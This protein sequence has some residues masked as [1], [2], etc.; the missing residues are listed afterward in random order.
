M[1]APNSPAPTS[2]P[3]V[4]LGAADLPCPPDW[5]QVEQPHRSQEMV[6]LRHPFLAAEAFHPTIVVRSEPTSASLPALGA[7]GIAGVIGGLPGARL[8]AHDRGEVGGLPAR[9]QV[10]AY[11]AGTVTIVAER[12][13]LLAG[14]HG[15]EITAQC[16]VEQV[17]DIEPLFHAVLDHT[18]ITELQSGAAAMPEPLAEPPRDG[19]LAARS[20][21]DAESLDRVSGAQPYRP[22]GPVLSDD[23]FRFA[24]HHAGR[25]RIGK[26]DLLAAPRAG[27][28][29]VA[30]G[31]MEPDGELREGFRL[32]VLPLSLA[33]QS[34]RIEGVHLQASTQ[35]DAWLGGGGVTVASRAS[36]AQWV[37]GDETTAIPDGF[38]CV[39]VIREESLPL[40][41]AAWA[42]VGPAWTVMSTIDRIPMDLFERRLEQGRGV[43][44]PDGA[45]EPMLRMWEQPWF[46][47]RVIMPGLE[48]ELSWLNAGSAGQYHIG[49]GHDGSMRLLAEPSGSVW[50]TLV[51][52]TG[53]LAHVR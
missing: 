46:A 23:T 8:L 32:M 16:T 36:H 42:G 49:Q 37:Q 44:P 52:E 5:E 35:F 17:E 9:G 47:W 10:Y 13:L 50:T 26:M 34:I 25:E 30:A 6:V 1:T 53:I 41:M 27:A 12:W 15:V 14:T 18:V 7:Q 20:G 2:W 19:F 39:D 43:P 40:A 38:V 22:V 21:L 3:R 45:D 31:L 33:R 24:I 4:R 28:E 29:L 51:R 48:R 11:D